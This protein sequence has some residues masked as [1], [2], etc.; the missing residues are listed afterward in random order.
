MHAV[1]TEAKAVRS[2]GT[3]RHRAPTGSRSGYRELLVPRLPVLSALVLGLLFPLAP[4]GMVRAESASLSVQARRVLLPLV[5]EESL[6]AGHLDADE[7]HGV[8]AIVVEVTAPQDSTGWVLYVRAEQPAFSG[9]GA[10]KPC[11]DLQWKPDQANAADYRVLDDHETVV[12]AN[13]RGGNARI[14]LD[15][16]LGMGWTSRPGTY[17]L[18]LIFRVAPY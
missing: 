11:T 9:E 3:S 4:A 10:G 6:D 14:A 13:P 7:A 12:A 17:G 1:S 8:S 2:G 18:G 5:I 16:R 15:V